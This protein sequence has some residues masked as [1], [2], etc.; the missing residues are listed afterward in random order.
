MEINIPVFP[1]LFL[2]ITDKQIAAG[3]YPTSR[4]QKGLLMNY[5]GLDLAEEAVGFGLPVLKRGF[6]TFFPGEVKLDFSHKDST[7]C[8]TALYTINLVEKIAKPGTAS[9]DNKLL[10]VTKNFL[11]AVIRDLPPAR[12]FLTVLSYRLRQWFNWETIFEK[13]EFNASVLM[14]YTFDEQT[15]ILNIE[16]ELTK[17][18]QEDVTETI[19]MNEQ[20]AHYF[21]LYRDSSELSLTSKAIGCWDE[22]TAENATF[23][24]SSFGIAFTL[25]RMP[26]AQLFRGRELVGPRLAWSGFGYSFSPSVRKFSYAIKIER[27]S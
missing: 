22:V 15:R 10:Y 20:G 6:Q 9:V 19:V 3:I 8:V 25:Q 16:A 1:D 11:A 21:D 2:T 5:C 13:S 14:T 18:L 27:L 24:S 7:W 4:L 17:P 26:A 23:A 12:R